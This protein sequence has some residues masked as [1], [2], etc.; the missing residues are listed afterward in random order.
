MSDS[1]HG[2]SCLC[3]AVR[4]VVTGDLKP[5]NACH[6]SQCRRMSGHFW[7]STEVADDRL[8]LNGAENVRWFASSARA[9]RGSCASCGSALFWKSND[10]PCTEIALGAF[11]KPTGAE[12]EMHNFVADKGDYYDIADGLPQYADIPPMVAKSG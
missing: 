8:T 3:G 7:V 1:E 6:C 4:F 12:I 10:A 2:G 9:T 11:D 5:A